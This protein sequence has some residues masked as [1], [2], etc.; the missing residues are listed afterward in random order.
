MEHVPLA[1]T[2]R[3]TTRLGFGG[4]ALMGSLN[5]RQSLALLEAAW[6]AGIR[7]FDVAPM[8]GWGEAESCLGEFLQRHSGKIT[9]ATKFGIRPP[10]RPWWLGL[11]RRLA[12][13]VIRR[14]TGAKQGLARAANAALGNSQ[15]SQISVPEAR[16]SLERSRAALRADRIDLWLLHDIAAARLEECALLDFLRESVASG[17]IGD[18]GVSHDIAQIAVLWEQQRDYCHVLQFEWSVLRPVPPFTGSFRI[19]HRALAHN[20]AALR[21]HLEEHPEVCH[22]WS[23]EVDY[24]LAAPANLAALMLRGVLVLNPGCVVLVSSKN[25]GHI[26]ANVR[27][28]DDPSLEERARRLYALVQRE[29]IALVQGTRAGAASVST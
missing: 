13:P 6:D 7:H 18:F 16:A 9:I 29:E 28:A 27:A 1:S 5:R 23:R 17:Q 25:P 8:Y 24:D 21:T 4:T 3:S 19:H 15:K 11:G 12:G 20:F 10:Q 22:D 26:A 2:G 14:A